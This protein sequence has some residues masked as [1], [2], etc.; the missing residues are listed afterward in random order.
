MKEFYNVHFHGIFWVKLEHKVFGSLYIDN[1]GNCLLTTQQNIATAN[2]NPRLSYF[3]KNQNIFGVITNHSENKSYSIK[4]INSFLRSSRIAVL[5]LFRYESNKCLLSN[6]NKENLTEL[7]FERILVSSK[8]ISRWIKTTGLDFDYSI[9]HIHTYNHIYR[10]PEQIHLF[11]SFFQIYVGF[12]Y[13]INQPLKRE[14]RIK[15]DVSIIIDFNSKRSLSELDDVR[16]RFMR[17]LAVVHFSPMYNLTVK[18]SNPKSPT[19]YLL[20]RKENYHVAIEQHVKFE[21]FQNSSQDIISNWFEK[22]NE[23]KEIIDAFFAVYKRKG[24]LIEN[25]FITYISILEKLHKLRV[26]DDITIDN[27]NDLGIDRNGRTAVNLK[28]RIAFIFNKSDF[29]D[30]NEIDLIKLLNK[31]IKTRNY[32]AHLDESKK[33]DSFTSIQIPFINEY[34]EYFIRELFLVEIKLEKLAMKA[35]ARLISKVNNAIS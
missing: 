9:E 11:T 14:A 8:L 21:I 23:L 17:L 27:S 31:I 7:N 20:S 35:D 16:K 30:N 33:E 22:Y 28:D 18:Y 10:R 1:H 3:S 34:L 6:F 2:P 32:H 19:D 4:M 24:V 12:D 26:S 29:F 5:D 15:E 13:Q 25:Q